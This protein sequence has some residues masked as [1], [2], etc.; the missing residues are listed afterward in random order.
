MCCS[1]IGSDDTLVGNASEERRGPRIFKRINDPLL[2][3]MLIGSGKAIL[4]RIASIVLALFF[5]VALS[6]VLSPVDFGIFSMAY[7]LATVFTY[8]GNIGQN[9][10]ILRFWPSLDEGYG[11]GTAAQAIR[12]GLVLTLAG[13]S[14]AT[15]FIAGLGFLPFVAARFGGSPTNLLWSG[16]FVLVGG[17]AEFAASALRAQRHIVF[18]LAPRDILWRLIVII[19]VVFFA[20]PLT[21]ADALMVITLV[22]MGLCLPQI[23]MLV[24]TIWRSRHVPL[25]PMEQEKMRSATWGLWANSSATSVFEYSTTLLVGLALGP[26]AAGAYFAADRLA[27]LLNIALLGIAQVAGPM[28]AR[29]YHAGRLSEVRVLV[30]I[31]SAIAFA[32][33]LA[34]SVAFVFFGRLALS[35]FNTSYADAWPVLLVL[36]A[37]QLV[38]TA[39]G[40]N[41]VLLA[42]AGKERHLFVIR[43]TLGTLSILLIPI[44]A[45][46]FGMI[47]AAAV[48]SI[49]LAAYSLIALA[50]CRSILGISTTFLQADTRHQD[51][52]SWWRA[53]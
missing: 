44:V 20:A 12:R 50:V 22:L 23:A 1:K 36:S 19:V 51:W 38:S 35:M 14:I 30:A 16:L 10:A 25:P 11:P 8:I 46:K 39:C 31:S 48:S 53:H 5:F 6:R 41:A 49:I 24:S 17:L 42:M 18:A 9:V 27:K 15:I 37:G 21:T 28:L 40:P 3:D 52:F 47:G 7:A 32:T 29:S 43:V 26:A 2:L 4:I 13:G 34:G 33:A 45:L